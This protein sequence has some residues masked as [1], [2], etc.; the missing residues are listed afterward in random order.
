LDKG[1]ILICGQEKK[2]SSDNAVPLIGEI[3][4]DFFWQFCLLI[5]FSLSSRW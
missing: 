1:L 2:K 5:K 3:S 4:L